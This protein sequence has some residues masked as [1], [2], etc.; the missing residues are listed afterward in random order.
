[1][2]LSGMDVVRLNFSH[3]SWS[4]HLEHLKTVR[5]LNSQYRRHIRILQDLE[6]YRIRIG[7]LKN[8]KPVVLTKKQTVYLTQ[9]KI[10]GNSKIIP[11]DYSGSLRT[12]KKGQLIFIDDGN[13]VLK[14]KQRESRQLKLD[15]LIGGILTQHKGVNMPDIDLEFSTITEKDRIDINFAI[16]HKV[17]YI[18]QSFVCTPNNVI[19]L[20]K[21][22]KHEHPSCKVI[23]K[24]ENS[25]GIRNID[26]I[27]DVS[28][29]IM[30]ARGDMGVSLPIYQLPILQKSIIRKCNNKRKLVITATQMLEN[31]VEHI[32]PTRAEVTDVANAIIDGTNYVMLSAE[33]AIGKYP[34]ETVTMMNDII[35]Y[36][37]KNKK[38]FTR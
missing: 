13:I 26:K 24:I 11:F 17:D 7:K 33:T 36:T 34:V 21:I 9:D 2:M 29:G 15:V 38:S 28:D 4:E 14:V 10:I 35:K 27:I 30:I 31:M 16:T 20:K 18:A 8:G 23:A 37:E 19:M 6:G 5:K 22:L 25:L 3:G 32:I 1:M 12:I